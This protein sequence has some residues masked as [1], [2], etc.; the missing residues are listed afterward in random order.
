MRGGVLRKEENEASAA[1]TAASVSEASNSGH[2]ATSE[3]VDG[4]AMRGGWV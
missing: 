3:Q 1:A 2:R 4:S